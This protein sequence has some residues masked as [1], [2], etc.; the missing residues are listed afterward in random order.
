M[1]CFC[2][3]C[4]GGNQYRVLPWLAA[5]F[6]IEFTARG[7]IGMHEEMER[8]INSMGDTSLVAETHAVSS[9]LKMVTSKLAVDGTYAHT[10]PILVH[11]S[12]VTS[13]LTIV[14][15]NIIHRRA[16]TCVDGVLSMV[17][18]INRYMGTVWVLDLD[19]KDDEPYK[20]TTMLCF[21]VLTCWVFVCLF[22]WVGVQGLR[23]FAVR[24]GGMGTA[25]S[26]GL[27]SSTE[28]RW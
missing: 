12:I 11:T 3:Q 5:A 16:H 28:T 15:V 13:C 9:C 18:K 2:A 20:N 23:S 10:T 26:V 1:L 4:L 22:A 7:M 27:T 25:V 8:R 21:G 14:A 19:L 6:A 24:A 17:T